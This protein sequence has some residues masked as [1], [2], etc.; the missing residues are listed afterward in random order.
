MPSSSAASEAARRQ[1]ITAHH[2]EH[3]E[4]VQ[5]GLVDAIGRQVTEP[6]EIELVLEFEGPGH[7]SLEIHAVARGQI[8]LARKGRTPPASPSSRRYSARS[9]PPNTSSPP[10]ACRT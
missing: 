2:A 10:A 8:V 1:A 3:A 7:G 5:E 9:K 4:H 6:I